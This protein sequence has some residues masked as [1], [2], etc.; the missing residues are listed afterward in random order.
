MLAEDVLLV[1]PQAVSNMLPQT[2][3]LGDTDVLFVDNFGPYIQAVKHLLVEL[4]M[5]CI[6]PQ[7]NRL[8]IVRP[9]AIVQCSRTTRLEEGRRMP[10]KL[11][12]I[13]WKSENFVQVKQK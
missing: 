10:A 8:W 2:K 6:F 3:P 13:R 4:M 11:D 9:V 5:A 7:K 1:L 12:L